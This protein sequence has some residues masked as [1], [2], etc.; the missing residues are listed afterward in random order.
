MLLGGRK[1]RQA[2]YGLYMSLPQKESEHQRS[3]IRLR[4]KHSMYGKTQ[5]SGLTQFIPFL[6]SSAIW[7]HS[8]FLVYLASWIFPA[9]QQS[10]KGLAASSGS[11]FWEP[12]FTFG[13]QKSLMAVTFLIYWYGRRHFSQV[14]IPGLGRFHMSWGKL[15][16]GTTSTEPAYSGAVVHFPT[17]E[18]TAMGSL[19]TTTKRSPCSLQL[20]KAQSW[21]QRPIAA[22]NN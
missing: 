12:S 1:G 3:G 2:I 10:P 14:Q 18:A 21:Q 15:S 17:R 20:E 22:K 8:G 7:G 6:C 11:Q 16:P 13:G 19:S 5:A 9:P 4:N